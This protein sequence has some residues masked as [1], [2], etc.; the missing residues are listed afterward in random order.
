M[1]EVEGSFLKSY[2]EGEKGIGGSILGRRIFS[3]T[4]EKVQSKEIGL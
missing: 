3:K 2:W 1:V 4:L